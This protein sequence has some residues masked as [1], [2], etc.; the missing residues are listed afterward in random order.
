MS[1]K[2]VGRTDLA[3]LGLV[4]I[5]YY[6][7]NQHIYI[8]HIF[9]HLKHLFSQFLFFFFLICISKKFPGYLVANAQGKILPK[10]VLMNTFSTFHTLEPL[11]HMC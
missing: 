2:A 8:M 4:K 7:N 3:T 11:F 5:K 6:D 10:T 9:S 1:N